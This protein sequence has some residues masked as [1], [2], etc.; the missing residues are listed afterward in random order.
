MASEVTRKIAEGS[1]SILIRKAPEEVFDFVANPEGDPLWMPKVSA[2]Q[3][4]TGGP[5]GVGTR[6]SQ[7]IP[8]LGA[9]FSATWEVILYEPPTNF[10]GRNT[11]GA[12][13]F[14][15]GYRVER[16]GSGSRLTKFASANLAVL[17]AFVPV[18]LAGAL[19]SREFSLALERLKRFFAEKA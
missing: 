14:E 8:L 5:I 18:S 2:V 12:I 13:G 10:L 6:F 15:G 11:E 4:L 7:T 19:I 17:P 9:P 1:A 16:L 3:K